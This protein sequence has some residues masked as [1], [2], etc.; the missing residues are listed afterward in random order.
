MLRKTIS[1]DFHRF[2]D[3][4]RNENLYQDLG[5]IGTSI[6]PIYYDVPDQIGVSSGYDI[7]NVYWD[8]EQI[9][10]WDTKSPYSNMHVIIGGRGRSITRATYSRN[11][12]PRWNFGLT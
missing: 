12:S 8:R 11:I 4:Q 2:N 7:F 6:R 3:V 9:K 1:R 5:V 10:Y